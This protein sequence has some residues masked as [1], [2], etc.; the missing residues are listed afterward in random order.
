M[1][2]RL[3]LT[4]CQLNPTVG[5]IEGNSRKILQA[6]RQNDGKTDLVVFPELF[7]CGY[8]AEDLLLSPLFLDA[9][10]RAARDILEQ[11][12]DFS[13]AALISVPWRISPEG[14]LAPGG[15]SYNTALLL[16]KG[17]IAYAQAKQKLPN[18]S[19][20]DE[21]RVF[22]PG[23][24]AAP[25]D[26]RGHRIGLLICEDI[27]DAEIYERMRR[28]RPDFIL[29]I[30][31][32]PYENGKFEKRVR[33]LSLNGEGPGTNLLYLNM[34][35]G[36]DELVFDGRSLLIGA[37]GDILY[38]SPAFEEDIVNA[39][40]R[41]DGPEDI[42]RLEIEQGRGAQNSAS[43]GYATEVE[44]KALTTGLRD[45]AGKNGF[46]GV[47]LGLS[48][49]VD[50]AL[51]A[52]IAADAIG[53]EN[54]RCVMMPSRFTSPE[55]LEDARQCAALLGVRYETVPIDDLMKAF[56]STLPGL[57]G[58]A[59]E[60]M[61][62]RIRGAI[63]MALSN[64]SGE[65]V[66]TTGNKSEMAAG[67]ATLYGDMNGGFSVLKDVY[68]SDI[69]PLC[70]WRNARG[71]VIPGRILS[72]APSAELRE[73]QKDQDSLPPYH[74]LDGIFRGLIED[75]KSPHELEKDGFDPQM[76][77]KAWSLLHRAEYKRRQAA[78][79]VK[80]SSRAFG[81]DRRYPLTSGFS[82]FV[83]KQ[84]IEKQD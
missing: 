50:S 28:H 83:E 44:Y 10:E 56:E 31:A 59:H 11:S 7:L 33:S 19:V 78:P 81:R 75:E 48:G 80:V 55:S 45:Y 49:G 22:E 74:L 52:A 47:L 30:N 66:L 27:W 65:L 16:E 12:A 82:K 9:V 54:V 73:N 68:K 70:L 23:N 20:F 72:K 46:S 39:I 41:S 15:K 64:A 21:M 8:P 26:F 77:Q 58:L 14:R 40:L 24:A 34:V 71:E 2:K 51:S 6:W 35:G 25:F 29:S 67:Y 5:D 3:G 37:A 13:S 1:G 36:Q 60:N 17:K 62:S 79:G 57:Q 61:Q 43:P 42:G 4:L 84:D 18:Y 32:S 38:E 53:Q 69:Y 76:I 63:L